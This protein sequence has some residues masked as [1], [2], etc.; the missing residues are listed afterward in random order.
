MAIGG[1]CLYHSTL[2]IVKFWIYC[3]NISDG[4]YKTKLLR[5]ANTLAWPSASPPPPAI[6]TSSLSTACGFAPL[7]LPPTPARLAASLYFF[8]YEC[9]SCLYF[10]L[11]VIRNINSHCKVFSFVCFFMRIVLFRDK[12]FVHNKEK[13]IIFHILSLPYFERDLSQFSTISRSPSTS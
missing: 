10:S 7:F 13:W 8:L 9:N 5:E 1:Y 6:T 11:L 2:A 3:N 12:N 4:L